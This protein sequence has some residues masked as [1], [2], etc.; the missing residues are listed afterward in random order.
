MHI[1]TEV[2]EPTTMPQT[3]AAS[4][5][6][7]DARADGGRRQVSFDAGR[8]LIERSYSGISMRVGIAA[9]S[10]AGVALA[11]SLDAGGSPKYRILLAHRD[12][13]LSVVLHECDG[14]DSVAEWKSWAR[15]FAL[16]RL[17]ERFDGGFDKATNNLG[18][19]ELGAA[20]ASRRRG[21][22]ISRRR[23]R[24]LAR[25]RIGN[26]SMSGVSFAGE[27]EIICYE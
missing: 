22:W 15:Y 12:A 7:V 6:G 25:R 27:R 9:S 3:H 24:F 5:T 4:R 16:P 11:L 8:V 13:D 26:A 21:A 23:P 2:I 1:A 10:Y 19:V 14:E 17:V 20:N 18:Q